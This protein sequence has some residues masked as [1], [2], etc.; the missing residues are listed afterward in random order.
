MNDVTLRFLSEYGDL[1]TIVSNKTE[2]G[3]ILSATYETSRRGGVTSARFVLPKGTDVPLYSSMNVML[4]EDN[5]PLALFDIDGNPNNR[6][7]DGRVEVAC[8]G[9]CERLKKVFLTKNITDASLKT[10]CLNIAA[11]AA[12]VGITV[13]SAHI[14]LPTNV[15]ISALEIED[16]SLFDFIEA[17]ITYAN[18]AAEEDTYSWYIDT[19]KNLC[20]VDASTLPDETLYEGYAF[21]S[22]SVETSHADQ[23]NTIIIWRKTQDGESEEY[24]GKYVDEASVAN[25]GAKEKRIDL[26]YYASNADCERIAHGVLSRY[27]LPARTITVSSIPGIISNGKCRLFLRP[28]LAWTRLFAGESKGSLDLSHSSG[29]LF[30]DDATSLVGRYSTKCA[31]NAGA[32]GYL[33]IPVDPIILLPQRVRL[34]IKGTAGARATIVLVDKNG[35]AA[36]TPVMFTGDWMSLIILLDDTVRNKQMFSMRNETRLHP[37]TEKEKLSML[38][39]EEDSVVEAL[40]EVFAT[41]DDA[42]VFEEVVGGEFDY[43]LFNTEDDD[44]EDY[45]IYAPIRGSITTLSEVRLYWITQSCNIWIDYVDCKARHWHTEEAYANKI[46]YELRGDRFIAASAEFGDSLRTAQDEFNELWTIIRRKK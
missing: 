4:T 16:L 36:E 11:D 40:G 24:V 34:M 33:G 37:L 5:A 29:V 31:L 46:T 2:R 43:A 22:P 1:V 32:Y 13:T 15:V 9:L 3:A 45:A 12:T 38:T 27:A 30:T 21:Q 6:G 25:Y 41:G 8:L 18:G 10:A 23:A 7:T 42:G 14:G 26:D 28:V 44:M 19:S 20:I 17:L 39:N 35:D